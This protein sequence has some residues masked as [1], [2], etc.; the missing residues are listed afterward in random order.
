MGWL[1]LLRRYGV[2]AAEKNS[3][4]GREKGKIVR[5]YETVDEK[6]HTLSPEIKDFW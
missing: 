6:L 3:D 1:Q 5:G 4:G 2:A